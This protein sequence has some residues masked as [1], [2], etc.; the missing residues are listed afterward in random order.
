MASEY[1]PSETDHPHAKDVAE[2][3][4]ADPKPEPEDEDVRVLA[5]CYLELHKNNGQLSDAWSNACGLVTKTEA[6]VAEL[7][8][9]LAD[10]W[11]ADAFGPH[12][13]LSKGCKGVHDFD[14]G[15]NCTTCGRTVNE[16]L[17]TGE[18]AEIARALLSKGASDGDK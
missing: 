17:A 8:T 10:L 9:A 11:D 2:W 6:R 7:E 1:D 3:L 5:R 18:R 4:L 13:L 14:G 15:V 16:I 12:P